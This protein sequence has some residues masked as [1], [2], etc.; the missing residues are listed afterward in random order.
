[1]IE[2]RWDSHSY[3]ATL[4][5]AIGDYEDNVIQTILCAVENSRYR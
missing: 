1:M 2:K 4:V 3:I 5:S